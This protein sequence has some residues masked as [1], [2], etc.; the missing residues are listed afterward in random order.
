[1]RIARAVLSERY[2]FVDNLD[3]LLG[4]RTASAPPAPPSRSAAVT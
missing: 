3:V 2:R 4:V 1:M